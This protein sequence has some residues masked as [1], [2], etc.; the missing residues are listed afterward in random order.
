MIEVQ[1]LVKASPQDVFSVLS[2]GWLYSGWVVGASRIRSV[3][4]NWP[5]VGSRIHHSFGV[6]PAVIDDSTSVLDCVPDH[7]LVLKARGWPMGEATVFLELEEADGGCLVHMQEDA[8]AGP[9][10]LVPK[11]VRQVSIAPRNTESLRRLQLI[12]EGRKTR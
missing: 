7:R 6:W 5:A 2:D 9:G 10:K 4:A 12:S 3:D 1:R 8:T 11:P